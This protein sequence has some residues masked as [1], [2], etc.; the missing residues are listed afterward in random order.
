[1]EL[2]QFVHEA[3]IRETQKD[4]LI[5]HIARDSTAIE[6]R[7][8]F[9]ETTVAVKAENVLDVARQAAAKNAGGMA[10]LSSG[11]GDAGPAGF[12]DSIESQPGGTAGRRPGLPGQA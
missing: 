10:I 8:R 6:A 1:M 3:L 11:F 5:G 9:P 4:R 7:E 2:P 12:A